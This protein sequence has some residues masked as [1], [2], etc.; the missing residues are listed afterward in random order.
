MPQ[1]PYLEGEGSTEILGFRPHLQHLYPGLPTMPS[2]GSLI[3]V[4]YEVP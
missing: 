4:T 3:P 1:V 2:E